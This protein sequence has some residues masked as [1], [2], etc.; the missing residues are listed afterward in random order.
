MEITPYPSRPCK[1]ESALA[2]F[3]FFKFHSVLIPDW[4]ARGLLS[5]SYLVLKVDID[6]MKYYLLSAMKGPTR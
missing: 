6:P 2:H 5:S 3:K 4:R 1:N